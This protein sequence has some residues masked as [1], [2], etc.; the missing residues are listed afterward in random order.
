MDIVSRADWGAK[1]WVTQ[2]Y[3]VSLKER[4]EFLVHYHGGIPPVSI[5]PA[6][7]KDCEAIH[8]ANGWSGIGYNFV[9]DEAGTAF[10]GRGWDLVG[11]HCPGHN[12]IGLGVY[13]A[14]GG[15]QVPSDAA[16]NTVRDIYDLACTKT[17]NPLRKTW[18]GAN[19]PTECPG[20]HLITWV[21]AG[22]P[23][24]VKEETAMA[25]DRNDL[26]LMFATG[27][28]VYEVHDVDDAGNPELIGLT[29]AATRILKL[30]RS[31]PENG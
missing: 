7:P 30:L 15:D 28:A 2:P 22:M 18:H 26:D 1:P 6:V 4:T 25:L 29:E 11:A 13:V 20:S 8:L 16:L 12:R 23:K 27:K 10:E 24:T 5:G 21:Q 17:G 3:T 9:V 31:R 19:Y 14:I